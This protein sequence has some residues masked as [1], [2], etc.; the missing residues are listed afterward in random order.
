MTQSTSPRHSM[1]REFTLD[2]L[3]EVQDFAREHMK[4]IE[5]RHPRDPGERADAYVA[6][7]AALPR[8][9]D[10]VT[11]E[12]GFLHGLIA[13]VGGDLDDLLSDPDDTPSSTRRPRSV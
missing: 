5:S 4:V 10:E 12:L 3:T 1:L 8:L 9:E 2:D 7:V 13:G 6:R 11:Y